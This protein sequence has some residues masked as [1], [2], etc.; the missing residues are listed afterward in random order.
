MTDHQL[1]W[2]SELSFDK[3]GWSIGPIATVV[4]IKKIDEEK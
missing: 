1:G 4:T 3:F 2:L